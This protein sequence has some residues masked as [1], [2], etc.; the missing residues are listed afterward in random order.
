MSGKEKEKVLRDYDDQNLDAARIANEAL[1][2]AL[3]NLEK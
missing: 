1:S 2:E 3:R